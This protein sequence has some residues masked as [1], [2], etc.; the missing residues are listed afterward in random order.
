MK[1]L[2][3]KAKWAI[4]AILFLIIGSLVGAILITIDAAHRREQMVSLLW[5]A[6]FANQDEKAHQVY[7]QRSPS[8]GAGALLA[9][10]NTVEQNKELI[11]ANPLLGTNYF[12]SQ[13]WILNG[14]LG[15]L[16]RLAGDN[17]AAN[18]HLSKALEFLSANGEQ[19]ATTNQLLAAIDKLD[20]MGTK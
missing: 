20:S 15:K 2:G 16:Y 11:E 5:F 19:L 4:I 3:V 6:F 1:K 8:E 9:F 7:F 18:E 14:R 10:L 12:A 13:M 17:A